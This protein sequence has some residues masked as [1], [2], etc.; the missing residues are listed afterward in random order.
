METFSSSVS[1]AQVS[2]TTVDVCCISIKH[3]LFQRGTVLGVFVSLK[4]RPL[5]TKTHFVLFVLLPHFS[6]FRNIKPNRS[7]L[8]NRGGKTAS[9]GWGESIEEREENSNKQ[10]TGGRGGT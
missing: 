7:V 5:R 9:A 10:N 1:V 6:L 4:P 3:S 2:K 8:S